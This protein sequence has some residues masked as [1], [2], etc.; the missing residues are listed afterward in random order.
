MIYSVIELADK[1]GLK[2]I[3]SCY[4]GGPKAEKYSDG[5]FTLYWRKGQYLFRFRRRNDVLK[6]WT[7][8]KQL[9]AYLETYFKDGKT[10]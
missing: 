5:V 2:Y 9:Q 3:G 7:P 6:N 4:C 1:Y 10:V 8:V